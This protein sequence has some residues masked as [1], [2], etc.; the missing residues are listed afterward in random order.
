MWLSK[1]LSTLNHKA[2]IS[3]EYSWLITT[4]ELPVRG[5]QKAWV[6]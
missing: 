3:S 4:T 5:E 2:T 6:A 1:I